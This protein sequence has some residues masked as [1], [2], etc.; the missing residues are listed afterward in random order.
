MATP[1][2]KPPG[3]TQA[4]TAKKTATPRAK[5]AAGET[6]AKWVGAAR[7]STGTISS[8]NPSMGK[9]KVRINGKDID[10]DVAKTKIDNVGYVE[11][12]V[13]RNVDFSV[14]KNGEERRLKA[15]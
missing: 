9:G 1:R 8:W 3:A 4:Q 11:L 14:S 2:P 15:L 13:G 6:R 12:R 7:R 10:F 5:K